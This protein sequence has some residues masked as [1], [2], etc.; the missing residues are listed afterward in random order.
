LVDFSRL[1]DTAYERLVKST[2]HAMDQG[3]R[4]RMY[5]Q[6]DRIMIEEAPILPQAYGR[7][8]MLVMAWVRNYISSP[9]DW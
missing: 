3:E 8:H 9:L 2:Q 6:A 5:A 4:M 7:F 1:A